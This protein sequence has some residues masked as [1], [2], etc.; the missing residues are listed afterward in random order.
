MDEFNLCIQK[1]DVME[2]AHS[3]WMH[4]MPGCN[5]SFKSFVE[6]DH[7]AMDVSL[8]SNVHKKP[9]PFK[10]HNFW[11]THESFMDL[12]RSAWD[13]SVEGNN[14]WILQTKLKS[15]KN[16]LKKL[17]R[18]AFSNI[19]SRVIEMKN[20][21]K[22][23]QVAILTDRDANTKLFHTSMKINHRKNLITKIE[24]EQGKLD[25]DYEHVKLNAVK[26][27]KDLFSEKV[28][29]VDKRAWSEMTVSC[30]ID[31]EDY[32]ML[33]RTITREKIEACFMSMKGD[34]APRPDG[35]SLEFY[36]D[37]WN[38]V[39]DSVVDAVQSF[40]QIG[41]MPKAM[42]S[43][44]LILIPKVQQ[45][46][47]MRNFK[48]IACYNVLYKGISTVIACRLKTILHKV[49]GIQQFTYVPGRHISD[50]ILLIQEVIN[51]YH[52]SNGRPRCFIKVDIMKAYDS[53]DWFFLWLM[54]E[55]LNFPAIF[56]SWIRKCVSIVWFSINLNGSLNG[57][58]KSSRALRQGDLLSSYLFITPF[59]PKSYILAGR[60]DLTS[61]H[62]NCRDI[63]LT[64][65]CFTDDLCIL[66]AAND[67]SLKTV[68]ETLQYFG[69]ITWLKPNLKKSFV[70]LAG[71]VDEACLSNT[72][73]IL[74]TSLPIKYLC[75]P[76]NTKE[77]NARDCRPL[78]DKIKQKANS[79][80][81]SN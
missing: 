52:K 16:K 18:E 7:C 17:N 5:V 23:T 1:I 21:W 15:I 75:I 20:E 57:Y 81:A 9:R 80:G 3:E 39:G 38:V 62:P 14:M 25:E 69:Q 41:D 34:K 74:N 48:S 36:K 27:Y 45:S 79:C 58:F 50:D 76:L 46:K 59:I 70:Y 4:S 64:N 31:H 24:D 49:V 60:K 19:S 35:L 28:N 11:S 6:S 43:T 63:K 29:L 73:E 65:V 33:Q 10:Y 68:K 51:G 78:V 22:T 66:S 30:K 44:S 26:F 12:V 2:V 37:A 72:L 53:V 54:L 67:R 42:N 55:K 77:L 56:I 8:Y 40:F 47:T 32:N 61:Y 71:N 13:V